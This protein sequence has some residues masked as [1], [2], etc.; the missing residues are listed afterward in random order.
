MVTKGA[1]G[2]EDRGS[3]NRRAE[4]RTEIPGG[5]EA[6]PRADPRRVVTGW[7]TGGDGRGTRRGQAG[8]EDSN[9]RRLRRAAAGKLSDGEEACDGG[10]VEVGDGVAS[11]AWTATKGGD[12]PPPWAPRVAEGRMAIRQVACYGAPSK[13]NHWVTDSRVGA[14]RTSQRQR[15]SPMT[16]CPNWII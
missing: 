14:R 3:H 16:I 6:P 2:R 11:E 1:P 13:T 12:D 15:G 10:A 9:R 8:G 7:A 5:Y 4:A